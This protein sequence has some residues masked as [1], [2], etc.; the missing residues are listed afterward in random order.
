MSKEGAIKERE[1]QTCKDIFCI[2]GWSHFSGMKQGEKRYTL[3]TLLRAGNVTPPTDR[4]SL[5][6]QLHSTQMAPALRSTSTPRQYSLYLVV[7]SQYMYS[8]SQR[9][10]L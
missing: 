8:Q 10:N 9:E 1:G 2:P 4:P 3:F 6:A 7:R 5:I